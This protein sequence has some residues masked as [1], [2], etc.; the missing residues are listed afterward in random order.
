LPGRRAG[1][2]PPD[3][4]LSGREAGSREERPDMLIDN[5]DHRKTVATGLLIVLG[6]F[7]LYLLRIFFL[8]LFGAYVFSFMFSPVYVWLKR[9]IGR[10]EVAAL[11]T[12]SLILVVALVPLLTV[13]YVAFNQALTLQD[14]FDPQ[15]FSVLF[16]RF[17]P[18]VRAS[19]DATLERLTQNFFTRLTEALP[20]VFSAVSNLVLS[21]FVMFFVMYYIFINFHYVVIRS[22][23]YLPFRQSNAIWL[24]RQFEHISRAIL[25]GQILISCLQGFL[26]GLGFVIFGLADAVLWGIMMAVLSLVP[27]VGTSLVWLPAGVYLLAHRDYYSG[28]GLLLWGG[29]VVSHIDNFVRPRLGKRLGNINPIVMLLGAFAGLQF[30]GIVGLVVGPFL[31]AFFL[32]LLQVYRQEYLGYPAPLGWADVLSTPPEE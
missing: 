2:R 17:S 5:A 24:V 4:F 8:A 29:I 15:D 6:L 18:K 7:L 16:Q 25:V 30:F 14:K 1:T 9:K 31:L 10:D 13:C 26:G 21:L 20:S 3:A 32:L 12:V 23:E 11:L 27:V 28:I 19:L 22:T